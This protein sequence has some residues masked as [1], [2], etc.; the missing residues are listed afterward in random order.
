MPRAPQQEKDVS[1]P[2]QRQWCFWDAHENL[3][4]LDLFDL[5][6]IVSENVVK[7]DCTESGPLHLVN[8]ST[9]G[10][11]AALSGTNLL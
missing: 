6:R 11:N 10:L 7:Y 2:P 1:T 8:P 5:N 3:P 4:S 9:P